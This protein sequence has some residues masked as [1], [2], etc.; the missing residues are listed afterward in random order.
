MSWDP[1]VSA[2][3]M[4][5]PRRRHRLRVPSDFQRLGIKLSGPFRSEADSSVPRTNM[6][7]SAASMRSAATLFLLMTAL[8][9]RSSSTM[10]NDTSPITLAVVNGRVWTGDASAPWAEAFAVRGETI[11]A[12]GTSD[13]IRKLAP[14]SAVVD[15]GG[16]LVV[17]GFIDSHVHFVDAGFRLASVQLR[18]AKTRDDFVRRIAA[19]AA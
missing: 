18:D 2:R 1:V 3:F 17:P 12:V 9:A 4:P 6:A 5:A 10:Q 8:V 14:P 16:K 19:F 7:Y 15:A 13:E 11:A